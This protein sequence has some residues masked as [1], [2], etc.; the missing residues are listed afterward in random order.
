MAEG[1]VSGDGCERQNVPQELADVEIEKSNILLIGPTGCGK[2][3]LAKTLARALDVPFAIADATT[4]TEAGYVGEDVETIILRLL[5]AANYDLKKTECGIVYVDE[6]DKIGRKADN[7][8]ISRDVSGEGV[9]QAL[10]KILEGTICHVPPKGGRKHPEQEYVAV[11]TKNILFI[12]GGAFTDLD[13]IVKERV[14]K[15]VMGF[16]AAMKSNLRDAGAILKNVQPE[17]L[18]KFGLIPEFIG[19]LPAISVLEELTEED[20]RNVLL[21]TKNAIVKQYRRLLAIDGVK[22]TIL[23]GAVTAIAKRALAMKTGARALRSILEGIMLDVM[24]RAPQDNAIAEVI[25]SEDVVEKKAEPEFI[26]RAP[27][28]CADGEGV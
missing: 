22:L 25:I 12:C 6:I 1:V 9:Q 7:V 5:Q 20:L 17:D 26:V 27:C 15:S 3:L 18:I 8:S 13:K 11:D 4:L 14:G 19:R 24:Y 2:T 16:N 21:S 23:D 10:L 28:A